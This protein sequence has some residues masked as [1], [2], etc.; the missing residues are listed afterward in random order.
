MATKTQKQQTKREKKAQKEAMRSA[1]R[2][3]EQRRNRITAVVVAA[4][5]LLAGTV[6]TITVF[7]ERREQAA[8]EAEQQRLVEQIEEEQAAVENREVACGAEVPA[9]ADAEKPT[10]DD[11]PPTV[12]EAGVDYR[13]V[14]ETSC[15]EVV[16]DLREDDAP[17]TV[18]AFVFLAQEGFYDGLEIFRIGESIDVLQ[19][20][21]GTN[22]AAFDIG[23]T[24]PGETMLAEEEGY[25]PGSVAMANRNDPDTGGSQFFFVYGEA[26]DEAF[27]DSRIYTRFADVTSGL[28]IL[29]EIGDAGAVGEFVGQ[30]TPVEIVYMESVRIETD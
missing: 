19:T 11:P 8:A 9:N 24:L 18:N 16:L 17:E 25:P 22:D 10:F 13:A 15:G 30:E 3:A 4:I 28:D 21:S 7:Q 1:A 6:A 26:F 20:G 27:E 5:V 23:Y 29:T 12:I 2:Q 14:I